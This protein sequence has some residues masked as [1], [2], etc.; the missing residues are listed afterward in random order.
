MPIREVRVYSPTEEH[1][2]GFAR[3]MDQRVEAEL[4]AVDIP[5]DA[6]RGAD[7]VL[8]ATNAL[9]PFFPADWIRDGMHIATV[10][11]S[12][13]TVDA[14]LRCN[15]L[16][17]SSREAARLVTLPGEEERIPELGQGDYRREELRGTDAD[18]STKPELGELM[19]GKVATRES[20]AEVTCMLNYVGLGLQF[21]AAG[22]RI[23]EL[24]KERGL[25]RELPTEWFSQ[26]QHS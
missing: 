7:I 8:L 16:V 3:E 11:S 14:L 24:A 19:A 9:A 23:Y 5:Q 25:G 4:R 13:M 15:R 1:R 12:E 17:V 22:A 10:R 2:R 6:A 21:A 18:W 20:P 26:D